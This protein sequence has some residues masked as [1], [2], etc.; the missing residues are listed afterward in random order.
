MESPPVQY[1]RTSDGYNLAYTVS[2]K[3]TPFVLAAG[4]TPNLAAWDH[5]NHFFFPWFKR[6]AACYEFVAYDGRGQGYSTRG[7]PETFTL[8]DDAGD[9][10][11]VTEYL[12]LD[13]FVLMTGG[14]AG[15]HYALGN[16]GRVSALIIGRVPA[17]GSFWSEGLF[18]RIPFENWELF[19]STVAGFTKA[20]DREAA[21]QSLRSQVSQA[22]WLKRARAIL[23]SDVSDLLPRL[24]MPVLVLH[25]KHDPRLPL[26]A[27]VA[28]A[29][30]IPDARLAVL[31]GDSALGDP[32]QGLAVINE[33]ITTCLGDAAPPQEQSSLLTRVELSSRQREVLQLIGKGKTS[34]ETADELVLSVRTV[35][36]HLAAIYAKIDVRNR[37]E[38]AVYAKEHGLI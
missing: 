4:H 34:R 24:E 19:L 32:D 5:P 29:A 6:F 37:A 38:A 30:S 12:G 28:L 2:G 27:S 3:G 31:D 26:E 20:S 14:H 11:T 18:Y 7:L 23:D 21:I 9:V 17:A 25:P 13:R 22:D 1:V 8:D 33:F 15:I 35:E 36:R 16:P 10:A